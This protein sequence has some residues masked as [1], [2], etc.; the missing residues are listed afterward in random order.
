M[1]LLLNSHRW[2]NQKKAQTNT[3]QLG[4]GEGSGPITV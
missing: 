3:F 4:E 2:R 1:N